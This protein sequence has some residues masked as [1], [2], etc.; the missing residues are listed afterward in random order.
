[1]QSFERFEKTP[2]YAEA[3]QNLKPYANNKFEITNVTAAGIVV[4]IEVPE[5]AVA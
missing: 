3:I 1:M 2:L 5:P 4:L